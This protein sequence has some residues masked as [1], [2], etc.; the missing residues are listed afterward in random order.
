MTLIKF[1]TLKGLYRS[2][3][4][5]RSTIGRMKGKML[6]HA[7]LIRESLKSLVEWHL[8]DNGGIHTSSA[9]ACP[10]HSSRELIPCNIWCFCSQREISELSISLIGVIGGQL[11]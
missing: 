8:I 6:L 2:L 7:K 9:S 3:N 1:N 10:C 11:S 5:V 4:R